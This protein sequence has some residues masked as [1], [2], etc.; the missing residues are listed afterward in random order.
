MCGQTVLSIAFLSLES[1]VWKWLV[2]EKRGGVGSYE[3]C[4]GR[5]KGD[6]RQEAVDGSVGLFTTAG[7]SV[8]YRQ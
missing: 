5:K 3:N 4:E 6:R 8:I 1:L 7:G 2:P